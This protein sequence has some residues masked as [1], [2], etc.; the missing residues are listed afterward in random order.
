LNVGAR[1][2]GGLW[3][4]IF[5][6]EA[7]LL[8][9]SVDYKSVPL[10]WQL[11]PLILHPFAGGDSTAEL[12]E[13][14]RAALAL[15]EMADQCFSNG[16]LREKM[17]RGRYQEIRMLLFLGKDLCRWIDQSLGFL[18]RQTGVH[19]GINAQSLARVIVDSP[20]RQ[21]SEKLEK[22]GVADRKAIF[23]RAIGIHSMFEA[24]P[25][26]EMLSPTFLQNYHRYADHAWMCFQHLRPFYAAEPSMFEF[27][28][29]ASEE[30]A[31]ILSELWERD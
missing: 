12:L 13:G 27:E 10:P 31:Q 17:L 15:E 24:P 14:S 19:P 9:D 29:F 16:E 5:G 23:S 22:W 25:P 18:A 1:L 3:R 28:L 21:V 30:Y 4:S 7:I 20:P 8:G 11:P 6:L 2:K 26:A